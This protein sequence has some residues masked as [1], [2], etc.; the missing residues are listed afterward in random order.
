M[1]PNHPPTLPDQTPLDVALNAEANASTALEWEQTL[2]ERHQTVEDAANI[3]VQ[4]CNISALANTIRVAERQGADLASPETREWAGRLM[5]RALRN[6]ADEGAK[7]AKQLE[8]VSDQGSQARAMLARLGASKR[9]A[10]ASRLE[11]F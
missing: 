11:A 5:I 7:M 9:L 3:A 1:K 8:A 10:M 2:Q 6:V 4:K